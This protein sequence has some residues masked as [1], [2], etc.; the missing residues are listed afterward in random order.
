MVKQKV[1]HPLY[2]NQDLKASLKD[3]GLETIVQTDTNVSSM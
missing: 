1:K 3:D 2:I